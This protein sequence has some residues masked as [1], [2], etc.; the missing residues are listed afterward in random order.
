MTR[1]E[2]RRDAMRILYEAEL[3]DESPTDALE[4][5]S[6]MGT[7]EPYAKEIVEGVEGETDQIDRLIA[8]ASDHWEL[9]RMPPVDRN[10]IRIGTWELITTA[11]PRAVVINEAIELAKEF[12]TSDAGQFVN[13]VLATIASGEGVAASNGLGEDAG[14]VDEG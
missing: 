14:P 3:R 13:G 2:A 1:R 6:S 8:A 11:T 7:V 4:R 12:S 10:L 5:E 9:S